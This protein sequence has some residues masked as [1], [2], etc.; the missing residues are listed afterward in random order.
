MIPDEHRSNIVEHVVH[1]HQSVIEYTVDYFVKNRRRNYVTPKHY[2]DFIHIYLVE[3]QER[4][5][6][7]D[8]QVYC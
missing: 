3:I 1:T 6:Y 2:L 8:A 7:I 5:A 4:A